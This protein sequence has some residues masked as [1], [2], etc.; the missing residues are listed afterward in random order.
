MIATRTLHLNCICDRGPRIENRE[1]C[2]EC[3]L[4]ELIRNDTE[5]RIASKQ[6][7]KQRYSYVRSL[8][9][10]VRSLYST[11]TASLSVRDGKSGFSGDA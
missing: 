6:I 9:L 11:S 8:T 3:S 2:G 1:G 10:N 5:G 4:A 7:I